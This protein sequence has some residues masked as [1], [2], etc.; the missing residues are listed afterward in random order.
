MAWFTRKILVN[1][2][3]DSTGAPLATSK[4]LATE[5]P[6]TFSRA[7][8]LHLGD[9]DWAVVHA[10]PVARKEYAKSG[11][12]TLRL[13]KMESIATE[14]ISYSQL[15]ITDRFGDDCSLKADEWICTRPLNEYLGDRRSSEL[16]SLGANAQEVYKIALGMSEMREYISIPNDGVYCPICHIAN[17][18]RRKLRTPCPKCGRELLLFGWD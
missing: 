11:S 10:E 12:L 18:D 1:F 5:L 15:D 7:A 3:D 8:K 16:P 13:R 17:I 4:M 9:A 14:K 2:I 6:E